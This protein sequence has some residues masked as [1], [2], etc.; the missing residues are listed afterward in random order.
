MKIAIIAPIDERIPPLKYGGI[1]RIVSLLADGLIDK[2]HEV[3]LLASGNSISKAKIVSI[4]SNSLEKKISYIDNPKAREAYFQIGTAKILNELV[5]DDFDIVN[6][7]LGWRLVPFWKLIPSTLITTLHTPLDQVNK[8]IAFAE[9]KHSLFISTSI[10]Q[11]RPLPYLNYLDN[12]YNGININ[13]YNFSP[14]HDD[15]FVFLGRIS[16]EKGVLEAIRIVKKLKAKLIIAGAVFGWN[17]EYFSSEIKPHIDGKNI[18]FIGEVNDREK[19][20]LLGRAK[21]LLAPI[22]WDEP[23]GLVFIEAMACGTPVV[24]MRRGSVPEIVIHGKSGFIADSL[25]QIVQYCKLID[26]IDRAFC[27][28]QA[29]C[30]SSQIMIDKYEKV[31]SNLIRGKRGIGKFTSRL[32]ISGNVKKNF[33]EGFSRF[34]GGIRRTIGPKEVPELDARLAGMERVFKAPPLTPKL[35]AAIKLISPHCAFTAA[36]EKYKSVW[37]ADQNGACWGEYE[38]LAPLFRSIPKPTKILEIGPGMGRS[39]VFFS[40]K[41]GWK[42]GEIHVYEGDGNTTKYTMLGPRYEDSYCGN[43]RALRYILEFNGIRNVTIFNARKVRLTNLPGPYDLLYSFY[44]IGFHWSLEHFLD[45]LLPLLHNQSVA[46]FTVPQEFRLFP[47]LKSLFYKI[48]N[49]KTVWPKD[50]WLKLLIISKGSLPI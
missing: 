19:N 34:S 45:D 12:I 8:K 6:N 33:H 37:E 14:K 50:G 46:V 39:V 24:S 16:P 26:T 49:W 1:G 44:G 28:K 2:G 38:A 18:K 15:Y 32:L 4:F 48:V 47:K 22:L 13:L 23:F 17:N 7:H 42:N 11:R 21:A 36:D 25:D 40:K 9:Y 20:K 31:F 3:T 43:I 29:Q 35:I 27:R 41:L 5:R 10:A 30:F